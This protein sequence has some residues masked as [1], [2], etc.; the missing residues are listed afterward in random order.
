MGAVDP[1]VTITVS[2][3][4]HHGYAR[5]RAPAV[6]GYDAKDSIT[7]RRGLSTVFFIFCP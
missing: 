3:A 7:A 1:C 5:I 2:S 4:G 6:F